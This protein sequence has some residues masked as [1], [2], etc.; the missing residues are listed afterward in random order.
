[1][2]AGEPARAV[3][4]G[5]PA[6]QDL[7]PRLSCLLEQVEQGRGSLAELVT[8]PAQAFSISCDLGELELRGL[9]RRVFGGRYVRA[10][11]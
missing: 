3:P 1:V 4:A 8:D 9:V 5:K 6:P 11:G 10:A 2:G 7:E